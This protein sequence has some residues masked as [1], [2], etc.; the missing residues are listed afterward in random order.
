MWNCRGARKK[1]TGNFLRHLVACNEVGLVGLVETK[2]EEISRLEVDRLVGREWDFFHHPAVGRSGG[3][4]L[5]WRRDILKV[6]VVV[7]TDQCVIGQVVL[8]SLVRWNVA[9]V[10]GHKDYHVRRQL[11]ETLGSV[12]SPDVPTIAGGDFNCC[13]SQDE[14][15]G[16]KRFRLSAGAQEMMTALSQLDLHDLGFSGPRYTWSNNKEGASRIWVHLD[17]ILINSDGLKLAP[18][19]S[20]KHLNCLASDHCPLLLQLGL[21]QRHPSPKWLR[22]E[23]IWTSFPA[24]W[25]VVSK[26]W[27]RLDVGNPVEVVNLK[28]R[29]TLRA[30]HFWSKHK[31]RDLGVRKKDLEERIEQLQ[32]DDCS[33]WG[34]MPEQDA[35]LRTAVAE[36]HSTL[37][38]LST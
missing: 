21:E 24:S 31:I 38:R 9:L 12:L 18:F 35:E 28:C 16:G 6:E 25:R 29:R 22:F 34:L 36:F 19:A 26:A 3:L 20:V 8:P 33:V 37:A 32:Q 14:K 15:K 17:R 10:Y 27:E 1:N 2:V 23:D 13:I 7:A 4:L 30:L 11:W 5:A